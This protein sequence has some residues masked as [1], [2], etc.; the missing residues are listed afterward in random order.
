MTC[1]MDEQ[2]RALLYAMAEMLALFGHW[3]GAAETKAAAYKLDKLLN[4]LAMKPQSDPAD[5]CQC[6]N[7][8]NNPLSSSIKAPNAL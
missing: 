2:D 1:R 5:E 6:Y 3:K 4:D 7:C 8:R